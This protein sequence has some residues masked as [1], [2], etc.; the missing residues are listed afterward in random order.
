MRRLVP[1]TVVNKLI[2]G[3]LL[4]EASVRGE[5]VLKSLHSRF[6]FIRERQPILATFPHCYGGLVES[7]NVG[8]TV[9]TE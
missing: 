4:G 8:G 6:L 2:Y 3:Y 7:N 1:S 5:P 9:V